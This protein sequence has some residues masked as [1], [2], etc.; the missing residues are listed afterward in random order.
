MEMR[1]P[2][3]E[4]GSKLPHSKAPFGREQLRGQIFAV[5]EMW[6]MERRFLPKLFR[7][8]RRLKQ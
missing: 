8:N 5:R 7:T 4:S 2:R 3:L 6:H 1:N